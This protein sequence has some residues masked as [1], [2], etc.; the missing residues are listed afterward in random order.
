[1]LNAPFDDCDQTKFCR[2]DE[3]G[4]EAI[5]L[6]CT[7]PSAPVQRRWRPTS[8]QITVRHYRCAD[9]A[10]VW[11]QDTTKAAEPR[12]TLSRRALRRSLEALA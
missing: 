12:A 9:C 8:L 11:R 10:H 4:L 2:L 5:G 7:G 3:P 1:V 6:S